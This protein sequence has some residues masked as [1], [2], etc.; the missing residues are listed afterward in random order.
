[1]VSE[2]IE[3]NKIESKNN[4]RV[5]Q[6]KVVARS[7]L[8]SIVVSVERKFKH[9]KYKKFVLR[10]KKFYAHDEL[11]NMNVGDFVTIRESRPLSASK[12]WTVI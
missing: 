2:T 9:P 10:S 3:Q 7:G 12:R 11:N 8:K 5:L 1:M 6:G 4:K